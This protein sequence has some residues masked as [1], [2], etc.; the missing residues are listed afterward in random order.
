MLFMQQGFRSI[1]DWQP[2]QL[3]ALMPVLLESVSSVI[4]IVALADDRIVE[5]SRAFRALLGYQAEDLQN[6]TASQLNIWA[7]AD[8]DT[9]LQT[10][11]QQ[12]ALRQQ[13]AQLRHKSGQFFEVELTIQPVQ[14]DGQPHLLLLGSCPAAM[15]EAPVSVATQEKAVLLK[16]I[17][18]R[19][20]NNLHLITNLLDLQAGMLHDDRLFNLFS[21]TQNRIQAMTLIHEQLYQSDHL[22]RVNFGEYLHRLMLNVFL[23]NSSDLESVKPILQADPVSLNLETA[24][25]CGLLIN[26]LLVNSLKHA[27]PNHQVGEV[28]ILLHQMPDGRVEIQLIDNGIG[29]P[30]DLDWQQATSLGFKLVRILAK[31]L[32][33]EIQIE[34]TNG[35]IVHLIFSELKYQPRF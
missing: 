30:A 32:K 25:P 16:E 23:S 31:Q 2:K 29:L 12:G 35:T 28:R 19:V 18:H 17:H 8:R 20:R 11:Y 5:S 6:C 21:A 15:N 9:F 10:V 33:A 3:P 1:T 24:V 27:F 14:L 13:T 26:E 7:L 22:G 34:R 4:A